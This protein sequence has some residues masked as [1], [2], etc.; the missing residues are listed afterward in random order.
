M[1]FSKL[2]SFLIGNNNHLAVLCLLSAICLCLLLAATWVHYWPESAPL[3]GLALNLVSIAIGLAA[4]LF[5]HRWR[6]YREQR[7]HH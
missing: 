7:R 6:V 5:I 2:R 3:R 1:F 4:A